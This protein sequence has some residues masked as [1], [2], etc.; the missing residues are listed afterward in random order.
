MLLRSMV[1]ASRSES[2]STAA[3][4]TALVVKMRAILSWRPMINTQKK[5][6]IAIEVV[7]DTMAAN[8]AP[9]PLPAPSSLATRTLQENWSMHHKFS[10]LLVYELRNLDFSSNQRYMNTFFRKKLLHSAS[11]L[12]S[13]FIMRR[14]RNVVCVRG[15]VLAIRITRY[16][17]K[18]PVE[19]SSP[20]H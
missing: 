12:G 15:S 2:L 5:S 10:I 7:D 11:P 4:R 20:I 6:P 18:M 8:L 16:P 17:R 9:F 1:K 14:L 19:S 13:E 3:S